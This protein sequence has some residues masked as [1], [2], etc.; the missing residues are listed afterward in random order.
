MPPHSFENSLRRNSYD[1]RD[2]SFS[3]VEEAHV[4]LSRQPQLAR[5]QSASLLSSSPSPSVCNT[6]TN[7]IIQNHSSGSSASIIRSRLLNRLGISSKDCG[8]HIPHDVN[9]VSMLGKGEASTFEVALKA[10]YGRPDKDLVKEQSIRSVIDGGKDKGSV[11][12]HPSVKV[13]TIPTRTAYSDRIRGA[14]WTHPLEMQQN[15]ARN[16]LE[17]AAEGWDWRQVADDEDMVVCRGERIHPIHFVRECNLDDH[18]DE[19][20]LTANES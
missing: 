3:S 10:D 16:S 6:G 4:T 5:S 11:S 12:F 15:A 18:F 14:L 13:H 19:N 8:V 20:Q 7:V 17:F 2:E 9:G 1:D